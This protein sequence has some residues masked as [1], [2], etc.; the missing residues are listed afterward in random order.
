MPVLPSVAGGRKCHP[1]PHDRS[2]AFLGQ[3]GSYEP[4]LFLGLRT[5]AAYVAWH[6]LP[7]EPSGWRAAPR[8]LVRTGLRGRNRVSD[9]PAAL[10]LLGVLAVDPE[11]LSP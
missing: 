5:M 6:A 11:E 4:A 1:N 9:G 10:E 7:I 2:P 8:P 3:R